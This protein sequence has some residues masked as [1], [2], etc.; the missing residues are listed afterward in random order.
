M[1]ELFAAAGVILLALACM[2]APLYSRLVQIN[3]QLV[4]LNRREVRQMAVGQD[5]LARITA[6]GT[7]L[8]SIKVLLDGLVSAGTIDQTTRDAIFAAI[9]TDDTKLAAIEAALRANVPPAT[10]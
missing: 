2:L 8:D 6:Q 5:I 7:A 1:L 4:K 3:H 10:P 9:G